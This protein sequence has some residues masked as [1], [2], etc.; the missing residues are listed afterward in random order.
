MQMVSLIYGTL[1]YTIYGTVYGI[2]NTLRIFFPVATV[3]EIGFIESINQFFFIVIETRKA[4]EKVGSK[5]S[6][7]EWT[8]L[9]PRIWHWEITLNIEIYLWLCISWCFFV[10]IS[11]FLSLSFFLVFHTFTY[12][13][14]QLITNIVDRISVF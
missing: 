3:W 10:S 7:D 11:I 1:S 13:P 8:K 6:S 9:I 2:R 14:G 4:K 12:L 5:Y